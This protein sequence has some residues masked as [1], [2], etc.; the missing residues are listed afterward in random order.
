MTR[1]AAALRDGDRRPRR[2]I[3]GDRQFVVAIALRR[4]LLCVAPAGPV[5]TGMQ[6]RIRAV[7]G[8]QHRRPQ[9]VGAR[10]RRDRQTSDLRRAVARGRGRRHVRRRNDP[11]RRHHVFG[12]A[13]RAGEPARVARQ[14]AA[15]DADRRDPD[16]LRSRSR[17]LV[18]RP[19]D[20]GRRHHGRSRRRTPA[21][22]ARRTTVDHAR[23]DGAAHPTCGSRSISCGRSGSSASRASAAAGSPRNSSTPGWCRISI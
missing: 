6:S 16:R 22:C 8:R 4:Q 2:G 13:S 11:P 1:R 3:D 23:R 18:Q 17:D 20:T 5:A 15:P 10:R 14:A 12:L 19:R 21:E 7:E 9:P